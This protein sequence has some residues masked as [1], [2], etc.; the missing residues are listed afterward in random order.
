MADDV[1][2]GCVFV[3]ATMEHVVLPSAYQ[4]A[5]PEENERA[6]TRIHDRAVERGISHGDAAGELWT[7]GF[8]RHFII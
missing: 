3:R 1:C 8:P 2:A 5:L 4:Q 6:L 7:D